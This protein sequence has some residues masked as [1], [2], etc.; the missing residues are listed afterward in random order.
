MVNSDPYQDIAAL[1]DLEHDEFDLDTQ[2]YLQFAETVGD[3]ILELACGTGRIL[4]ALS[5][6]S[7]QVTGADKSQA[8]LNRARARLAT[9]NSPEPV[10]LHQAEMADA[11][12]LPGGPF[13]VVIIALDGLLH[14]LS[15][16]DQL[17][18]LQSAHRALDPRGLL[19]LDMFHATPR[20][21]SEIEQGIRHDGTWLF[22]GVQVDKFSART[23]F[24]AEQHLATNLWYDRLA[25]DGIVRRTATSFTQ[26]YIT[27]GE[28]ALLLPAAGFP[29]WHFYGDYELSPFDDDSDR[30]IV[31]AEVT[32]AS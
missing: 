19:L 24:P 2:M 7:F 31:A 1:Y 15:Q 9:A 12:G 13:G 20:R 18:A 26:R 32:G 11:A 4:A 3:P 10:P 25:D 17:A 8:M 28:M 30:L 23:V 14:L 16:A 21:L 22:D 5:N 29:E 6:A 27:P